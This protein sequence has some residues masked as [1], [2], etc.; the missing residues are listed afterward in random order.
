MIFTKHDN[1][2]G[3][4]T[5]TNSKKL[6]RVFRFNF[7]NH[8]FS[9]LFVFS[10]DFYYQS[11]KQNKYNVVEVFAR[12]THKPNTSPAE[13]FLAVIHFYE[14]PSLCSC[15]QLPCIHISKIFFLT[16]TDVANVLQFPSYKTKAQSIIP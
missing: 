15:P 2:T 3:I 12:N 4:D 6:R 16:S 11:R 13:A 7:Q 1:G 9:V 5:I 14:R 10:K 8:F